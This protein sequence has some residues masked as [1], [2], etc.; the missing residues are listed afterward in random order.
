MAMA[1]GAQ[2][3][4][5]AAAA[6][7]L[8]TTY[9]PRP[10]LYDE[11]MDA[12]GNIRPHWHRLIQS[13]GQ[14][15]ADELRGR[16]ERA[17]RYLK[18]SG[19]FHRLYDEDPRTERPWPLSHLP[20]VVSAGDWDTIRA[21]VLQRAGLL[22]AVLSDIYGEGRC[23]REGKLPA[24]LIAGSPEF[25]RPLHGVPSAGGRHI[26]LYAAD[27]GRDAAGR[28]W[29]IRDR[30]QAPSG[31]GYALEN[32]IAVSRALGDLYRA[33]EI[34]R[35]APFFEAFRTR[36][37]AYRQPGDAGICL[38]TPGPLNEA[39]FEHAYLA[40]YLGFRLVEGQDLM[41]RRD[42][43]Y[44][45]TIAGEAPVNALWRRID[46]DFADPIELNTGSSLGVPGLTQAVRAGNLVCANALGSGLAEAPALMSFLPALASHVLGEPLAMPNVATWWCGQPA[47]RQFVLENIDRLVMLPAL[48]PAGPGAF[49]RGSLP[50]AETEPQR[51]A[52]L[53]ADILRRGM[54]YAGQEPVALSTV[55]VWANGQL[56]PRPFV[57]RVYA[58]ATAE[59][60][61]IM[62]G[63]LALVGGSA[64]ARSVTFQQGA[65]S[66]DVWVMGDRP[67]EPVTLLPAPESIAVRRGDGALPSRVADNLFWLARYTERAEMTLR[68]I[69]ALAGRLTERDGWQRPDSAAL[70]D[71]LFKWGAT[72]SPSGTG[73][74][75]IVASALFGHDRPG[76]VVNLIGA[77][78]GA[79]SVIRDRIPPDAWRALEDVGEQ[80]RTAAADDPSESAIVDA[81]GAALRI[82]AAATAL[83]V[84]S[85]DRL[86]GWHFL[87]LGARIERGIATCRI[88]RQLAGADAVTDSLEALLELTDSHTTYRIRYPVAA[89]LPVIDLVLLDESNPRSLAFSLQRIDG[90][91]RLLDDSPAGGTPSPAAQL[92]SALVSAVAELQPE[93]CDPST[94]IGI[95]NQL[96]RLSG[97]FAESY[98]NH[99][100]PA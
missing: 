25:L 57:L 32:R 51:R 5:D 47:E 27:V 42:R 98:F 64:D 35:L 20:L 75:G 38:L 16:F 31:M 59:G 85:M 1:E 11:M 17:D 53:R 49:T 96:M 90:H 60:W 76:T 9:R 61:T 29:V 13:I 6:A 62:P 58:A 74:L 87:Q 65:R 82:M 22:E 8:L 89:R 40:R 24:L 70:L 46:A 69:R 55:P 37:A 84:E 86:S 66:A 45:R 52:A 18:R 93:T 56:E 77:A 73:P 36:L 91:A 78:R 12:D 15:G 79:M 83:E 34:E 94:L 2:F 7:S 95:E 4:D 92:A 23:V 19:V 33:Y 81:A 10:G 41:V 71:L 26:S 88:T 39:Y 50:G 44:L 68:L 21:G 28:W 72:A 48:S 63:G 14:L 99:R 3:F 80:L 100:R 97:V 67:I 43:V 30:T 54:D